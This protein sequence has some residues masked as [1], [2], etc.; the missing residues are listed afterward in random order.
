MSGVRGIPG[1]A[2]ADDNSKV[3]M[4]AATK[5]LLAELIEANEIQTDDG[6]ERGVSGGGSQPRWGWST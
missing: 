6:R 4:L 2:T 5:E 3:S 1:A